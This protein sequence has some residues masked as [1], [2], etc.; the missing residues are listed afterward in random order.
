[1]PGSE[2][3]L[4]SATRHAAV[5]ACFALL[6]IAFTWPLA[7][8]M[9]GGVI[10]AGAGDNVG[11]IWNIWWARTALHG[12]ERIFET[13][14]LFAPFG[15]SLALHSFAP[16]VS[17][18][19][20]L[21]PAPPVTAYNIALLVSV[22][23]NCGCA[24]GAAWALTHDHLAS[25]FAGVAFGGAPFLTVR[26]HGHLNVL[27]AWGLPLLLMAAK[28]YATQPAVSSALIVGALLAVVGYS[29]AYYAIF[30]AVLVAAWLVLSR[31]NIVVR[32]LAL[33]QA[34][35][36]AL[37]GIGFA[38][39]LVVLVII[40]IETTGGADITRAGLRLRMTDTFN[41]RVALGFLLASAW[42]VWKRPAVTCAPSA[43]ALPHIWR[44]V[45]VAAAVCALMLVPLLLAAARLWLA[46]D[47]ESQVYFW[48]SA[49][50]GIDLG[51]F[52]LGN[53]LGAITG[54]ATASLF[55]RLGIDRVESAVWIGLAPLALAAF[56]ARRLRSH[57]DVRTLLWMGGLFFL[58]SLGPYLR[59]FG[60]N[61][62]FMLPQ[63]LAR[64]VPILSNARIPGRAFV[65]VQLAIA[66]LGAL[67]LASFKDSPWKTS[68]STSIGLAAIVVLVADYAPAAHAWTA[69][70]EDTAMYETLKEQPPGIVLELPLGI[71][72]GFGVRGRLDHRVL[73]YQTIHGH[74]LIGGFV[75]R[76]SSRIKSAYNADPV[77]S[78]F[79]DLS[80]TPPPALPAPPALSERQRVEGPAPVCGLACD[81]RYVV[82]DEAAA[83]GA[84][85]QFAASVFD[86][87][88][89]ASSGPRTLYAVNGR[90]GD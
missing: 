30:G 50:P 72:D 70:D 80:E 77:I 24:Y 63:T 40:W 20:A 29:D 15:T 31:W 65:V 34:R 13:P 64:Y 10:G 41:A 36:R 3:P 47:Y 26:L 32:A 79:L 57:A 21:L 66:L 74:P 45:T 85:K 68:T 2:H 90:R 38:V 39:A 22:F 52:V 19:A 49:P 6:T 28:R 86:L 51:A 23:L 43:A 53:P 8:H 62:A 18:A 69:L 61:T 59:I 44:H 67:A 87:R 46:G 4:H 37:T 55:A 71:R 82:V 84:L 11:P 54:R 12:P 5:F 16:L 1:M 89:L 42:I 9:S 83:S 75:A 17:S 14:A 73:F 33:T 56:A 58:W 25:C 78:R 27:S 7:A 60:Y 81:V 76:L 88:R 35:R 48:R